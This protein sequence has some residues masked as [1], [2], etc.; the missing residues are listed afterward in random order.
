MYLLWTTVVLPGA[1]HALNLDGSLAVRSELATLLSHETVFGLY[2]PIGIGF[3][4]TCAGDCF[5]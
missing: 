1:S 2:A 3:N 5:I 4:V